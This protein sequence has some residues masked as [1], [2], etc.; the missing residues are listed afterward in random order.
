M[1]SAPPGLDG[2]FPSRRASLPFDQYHIILLMH[3]C[4]NNFNKIVTWQ[5]T[6]QESTSDLMV[7]SPMRYHL[8]TKICEAEIN[9]ETEYQCCET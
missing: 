7:T 2:Y 6:G 5:C 1:A 9:T 8:T 3:M 4:V